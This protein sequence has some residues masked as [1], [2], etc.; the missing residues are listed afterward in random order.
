MSQIYAASISLSQSTTGTTCRAHLLYSSQGTA[1]ELTLDF[2]N[3]GDINANGDVSEWLYSALSR[4]MMD[5]DM[6]AVT[7]ARVLPVA[8]LV[9]EIRSEA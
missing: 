4:L 7:E 8:R 6:H 3:L 9:E 1:R 2:P 5:Y